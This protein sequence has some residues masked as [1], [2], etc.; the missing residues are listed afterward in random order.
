MEHVKD[1]IVTIGGMTFVGWLLV[2]GL[3]PHCNR[4]LRERVYNKCLD[5]NPID[6]CVKLLTPPA[7]GSK[8]ESDGET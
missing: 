1:I 3:P 4:E 5:K 8:G 6:T 7:S 2:A